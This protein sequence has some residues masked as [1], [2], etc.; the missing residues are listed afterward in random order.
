MRDKLGFTMAS[1]IKRR[2]F[3]VLHRE[4]EWIIIEKGD[5]EA[6]KRFKKK[7]DAVSYSRSYAKNLKPS[8]LRIHT[9]NSGIQTIH[10]YDE[11]NPFEKP[12]RSFFDRLI[13]LNG[14]N[15]FITNQF[16]VVRKKLLS[17]KKE[18]L[19]KIFSG[20]LL[21]FLD[22]TKDYGTPFPPFY[23]SGLFVTKGKDYVST[24]EK[25]GNR[26]SGWCI[27][28]AYEAFE[29]YLYNSLAMCFY[30]KILRAK[31]KDVVD[32]NNEFYPKGASP[33]L[34]RK[35]WQNFVREKYG[36]NKKLLNKIRS[37]SSDL[38]RAELN[39]NESLDIKKWYRITT[40]VRHAV[41]HTDFIIAIKRMRDWDTETK[42]MLTKYYPGNYKKKGYVL[43]I[44]KKD[45]SINL[46]II[47]E[48]S[49]QIFKFLSQKR[50][51]RW[52]IFN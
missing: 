24:V 14:I 40:E 25:L 6:K 18:E 42:K 20:S 27:S 22:I 32:F 38:Q 31:A 15:H 44:N 12:L 4:D 49:Y 51:Y 2:V 19:N 52:E 37:I 11:Y 30:K 48:Y 29:T 41:T 39:N 50:D 8:E 36:T 33:K 16:N 43:E 3:K 10:I 17:Y 5:S 46:R 21:I 45:A 13:L 47:N 34:D 26:E 28:Q 35:Y 9:K 7:K 23:T 1:P